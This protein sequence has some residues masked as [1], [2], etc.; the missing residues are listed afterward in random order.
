MYRIAAEI[1]L[2]L[3][4]NGA[5]PIALAQ[6]AQAQPP[7]RGDVLRLLSERL[8]PSF[9][10]GEPIKCGFPTLV[11]VRSQR[12][13]FAPD[14]Q[15]QIN[16]LLSRPV[17]QASILRNGYR[18]HFDTTGIDAPALLDAQGQ[19][20]PGTALAFAEST[21]SSLAYVESIEIGQLG[22]PKPVSD[23][24]EGGGQEP[25]IY[26]AELGNSYGMTN[27]DVDVANGG[28]T[29]GY[30]TIDNDF[31]FVRPV[32]N[33]G[34]P[35]LKITIAH[36][37]HHLIQIGNY[38]LWSDD[39]YFY[40]LT[41]TWLEDVVYTEVNDYYNYLS[42]S[43]SQ[44]KTPNVAFTSNSMIEYSRAIWG[45]FIAK[46][47]GAAMMRRSWEYVRSERPLVAIDSALRD[48]G[49]RFVY[50]FAEWARWNYYTG[51][52]ADI[53]K[54]YPEGAYYPEA[55]QVGSDF[56]APLTT[57]AGSVDPTGS[58]YY[59][60]LI[61]KVP[62]QMD[63]LTII[64]SN[65]N[66]VGALALTILPEDYQLI[67]AD[68]KV[69]TSYVPTGSAIF[70]KFFAADSMNWSVTFIVNGKL[71][72]ASASITGQ[73]FASPVEFELFQNYPNPFNPSTTIRYELPKSALVILIVYDILGREVSVL[74]HERKDAGAHQVKFDGSYLASGVY[75]YR[76]TAGSF[77]QIR[78][79]V[80]IR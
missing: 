21:A 11:R 63:T 50:A 32:A 15:S 48:G 37:F 66:L 78:K 71:T 67:L 5:G 24:I 34:I 73:S 57:L 28:R 64:V 49:S 40:E 76:L 79:L 45:H 8:G 6:V 72:S 2:L 35:A 58:R 10:E 61:P 18:I 20:I 38:G 27:L 17:L 60:V 4:F 65:V 25:D 69:D 29:S 75:L 13:S 1:V 77:T 9:R 16:S 7:R 22:Y 68:T 19:R 33:Q 31:A 56:V 74:V 42:T 52:R 3:L 59:Q 53:S 23:G 47:Y 36:E 39:I 70:V 62:A 14:I 41:S 12:A 46:A 26:I 30:I 55:L 43:Y 54:Y 80:L 44:F 51:G